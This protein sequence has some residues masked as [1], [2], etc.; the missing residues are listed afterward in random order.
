MHRRRPHKRGCFYRYF[1]FFL[2]MSVKFST[3]ATSLGHDESIK[4]CKPP[5]QPFTKKV[6]YPQTHWILQIFFVFEKMSVFFMSLPIRILHALESRKEHD[7]INM[8]SV[9]RK[10]GVNEIPAQI[11][12]DTRREH[13]SRKEEHRRLHMEIRKSRRHRNDVSRHSGCV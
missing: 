7:K 2:E 13:L 12:Y 1:A 4:A 9:F 11:R 5:S 8:K 10:V 6:Q 3:F